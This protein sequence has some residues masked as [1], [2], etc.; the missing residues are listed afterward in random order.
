MDPSAIACWN[1]KDEY[2]SNNIHIIARNE[3]TLQFVS[4][5]KVIL[6]GKG[7]QELWSFSNR[8]NV[9]INNLMRNISVCLEIMGTNFMLI[10]ENC[11]WYTRSKRFQFPNSSKSIERLN[12]RYNLR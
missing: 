1:P 12:G 8:F 5:L 7:E 2:S 6:N 3:T 10:L 9:S 4:G 11:C